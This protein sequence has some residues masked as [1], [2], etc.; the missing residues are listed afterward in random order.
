[1]KGS[2]AEG[3]AVAPTGWIGSRITKPIGRR[4]VTI[5]GEPGTIA[6]VLLNAR[7]SNDTGTAKKGVAADAS[8]AS[9]DARSYLF[10]VSKNARRGRDVSSKEE[11]VIW[12]LWRAGERTIVPLIP[13]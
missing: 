5:M 9:E 7:D 6:N 1:M 12:C 13:E 3:F 4:V 11:Y 8:G 2:S 10:D